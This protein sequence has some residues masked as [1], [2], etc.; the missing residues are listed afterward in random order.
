MKLS[1]IAA[2]Q[3]RL[4]YW[5]DVADSRT[6]SEQLRVRMK[7]TLKLYRNLLTKCWENGEIA[8]SDQDEVLDLERQLELLD[9]EA[10]LHSRRAG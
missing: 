4:R 3:K 8:D 10:R 2:K 7:D 1:E 5:A 9:E 6:Y